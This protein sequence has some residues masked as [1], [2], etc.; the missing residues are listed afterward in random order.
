MNAIV[1]IWIICLFVA[2]I[3]SYIKYN[4]FVHYIELEDLKN[5]KILDYDRPKEIV[6]FSIRFLNKIFRVPTPIPIIRE[7]EIEITKKVIR[8]HNF[9]VRA[10]WILFVLPL[11][12]AIIVYFVNSL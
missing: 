1:L 6:G 3:M 4:E 9:F 8:Q 5:G 2:M 12:V 10:F 7:V 11:L